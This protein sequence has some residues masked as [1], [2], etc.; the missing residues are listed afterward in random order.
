MEGLRDSIILKPGD[1]YT[2]DSYK[3]YKEAYE[4]LM[5]IDPSDLSA[6]EFAR[7]KADFEK[8]ELGLKAAGQAEQDRQTAGRIRLINRER[9][10]KMIR[11]SRPVMTAIYFPLS[12]Y[13]LSVWRQL[14]R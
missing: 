7:L 14:W 10:A 6:E 11:Q 12:S 13:C 3:A 4:A 5:N 1:G 2:D 9:T 8:A